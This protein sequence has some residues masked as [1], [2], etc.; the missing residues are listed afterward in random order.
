MK[1]EGGEGWGGERRWVSI[2]MHQGLKE[3]GIKAWAVVKA[4]REFCMAPYARKGP[5]WA[6]KKWNQK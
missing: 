2:E 4:G 5:R 3:P 1:P 6:E